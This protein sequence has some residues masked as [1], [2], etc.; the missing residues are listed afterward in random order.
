MSTEVYL[1]LDRDDLT[2]GLQL[3]VSDGNGG[4]RIVGPKFSG[5]SRRL[6]HYRVSERDTAKIREY[7]DCAFPDPRDATI[8]KLRAEVERLAGVLDQIGEECEIRIAVRE[9][10]QARILLAHAEARHA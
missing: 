5:N 10:A 9:A 6:Q 2:G 7:L 4:Y 1:D 8:R 3:S